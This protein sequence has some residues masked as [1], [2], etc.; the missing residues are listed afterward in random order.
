MMQSSIRLVP[1]ISNS[2][3]RHRSLNAVSVDSSVR[4]TS[5]SA[6]WLEGEEAIVAS[7]PTPAPWISASRTTSSVQLARRKLSASVRIAA[8]PS[9]PF[10]WSSWSMR[11]T[12]PELAR[13]RANRS[14]AAAALRMVAVTIWS[15][16]TL[17]VSSRSCES[18]A[19]SRSA[20]WLH[21]AWSDVTVEITRSAFCRIFPLWETALRR[22]VRAP[23]SK[24]AR[25]DWWS[26]TISARMLVVFSSTTRFFVLSSAASVKMPCCSRIMTRYCVPALA[27]A[28]TMET[29]TDCPSSFSTGSTLTM[30]AMPRISISV[31][32]TASSPHRKATPRAACR[33]SASWSEDRRSMKIGTTPASIVCPRYLSMAERLASA[34]TAC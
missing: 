25:R 8:Q 20:S 3:P 24:M 34:R 21:T 14:S 13:L 1:P 7:T 11:W 6:M 19:M 23:L 2:A 30:V 5:T 28:S 26:E 17:E 31:C 32:R 33:R 22:A 10:F 27:S 9:G 18:R 12:Q 29:S 15:C 4:H 16:F